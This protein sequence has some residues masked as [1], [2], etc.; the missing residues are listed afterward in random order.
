MYIYQ[1]I[2]III[3]I[4]DSAGLAILCDLFW[5][6]EVTLSKD[7]GDLQ[8]RDEKVTAWIAH[9]GLFHFFS[10]FFVVGKGWFVEAIGGQ[11][12]WDTLWY[13]YFVTVLSSV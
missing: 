12:F 9:L 5:D 2:Y 4:W 3:I 8:L 11:L 7:V 6:A 10:L 1:H 13:K